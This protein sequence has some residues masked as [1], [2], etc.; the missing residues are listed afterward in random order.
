MAESKSKATAKADAVGDTVEAPPALD[1]PVSEQDVKDA[2]TP[3]EPRVATRLPRERQFPSLTT[4]EDGA[5]IEVAERTVDIDTASGEGEASTTQH[6]KDF[7][8]T[9]R[10][11]DSEDHDAVHERNFRAVR[12][13]MVSQGL[14][15]DAKVVFLGET[16]GEPIRFRTDL[17]SVTLRYGVEAVPAVVA[18]GMEQVHTVIDQNGPNAVELAKFQAQREDRIRAAHAAS[19]GV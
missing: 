6:V 16:V 9:Q 5:A 8:T 18:E 11:W 4:V 14:R 2:R 10:E 13:Y 7:V 12:Q 19:A 1:V 17:A 3:E 15:P